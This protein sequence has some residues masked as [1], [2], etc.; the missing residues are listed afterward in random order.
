VVFVERVSGADLPRTDGDGDV[1][2]EERV[3]LCDRME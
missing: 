3:P 1:A 2:G